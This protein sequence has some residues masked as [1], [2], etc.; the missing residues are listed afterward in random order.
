MKSVLIDTNIILDIALKREPHF[1]KSAEV[2]RYIEK[3][4]IKSY[5]I[6][7]SI[8]D[9]YY[10]AHK[11]RGHLMAIEFILNLIEFVDIIGIDK[12]IIINAL[13]SNIDDFEDALQNFAAIE[14]DCDVII[15]RNKADFKN[16][17]INILT[18][19]EFLSQNERK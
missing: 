13:N 5:V 19:I 3:K 7:T 15:T 8:N 14:A 10:I 6:A 2:F 18:P 9:I 1:E 16:S 11:E 17:F 4:R 12:Q